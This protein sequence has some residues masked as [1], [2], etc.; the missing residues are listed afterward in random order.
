MLT[1]NKTRGKLI[2]FEG[3]DNSGK[4]TQVERL[5]SSKFFD[6]VVRLSFPSRDT[7]IGKLLNKYLK[8]EEEINPRVTH[9]L[10]SADRWDQ[11]KKIEKL[12]DEGYV[13]ILDRYFYSGMVYSLSQELPED[14]CTVPDKDLLQPDIIIFMDIEPELAAKRKGYG[15]EVLEKLDLQIKISENYNK[16]FQ[17]NDKVVRIDANDDENV[18]GDNI[19]QAVRHH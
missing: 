11:S 16:L 15:E 9:L 12:I 18:I 10:F 2:V 17:D 5:K 14:F 1:E 3:I 19:I 6:K 4:T 7:K 13:V 8:G